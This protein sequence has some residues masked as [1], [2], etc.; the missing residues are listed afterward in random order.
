MRLNCWKKED[1]KETDAGEAFRKDS[2]TGRA[3]S[4]NKDQPTAEPYAEGR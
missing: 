3:G 2:I 4:A 1:E